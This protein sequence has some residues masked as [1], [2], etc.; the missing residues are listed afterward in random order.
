MQKLGDYT[1]QF[2][3][4]LPWKLLQSILP[5]ITTIGSSEKMREWLGLCPDYA[6]RRIVGK[7]L[8]GDDIRIVYSAYKCCFEVSAL[9]IYSLA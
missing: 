4:N 7:S 5:V 8:E 9:F 6:F 3:S 1:P 2:E